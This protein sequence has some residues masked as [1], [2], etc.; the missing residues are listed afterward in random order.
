MAPVTVGGMDAFTHWCEVC[1]KEE[2]LTSDEAFSAG[3][4][5]PPGM[6]TW[7]VV[8][9]RTCGSCPMDATVWWAVAMDGYDAE[10]L[11]SAQRRVVARIRDETPGGETAAPSTDCGPEHRESLDL[12]DGGSWVVSTRSGSH[13]LFHLDGDERSV[14]RLTVDDGHVHAD[15]SHPL[16][17][18]GEVL[19]LRGLVD[20][21]I[22]VGR[23]AY[24]VLGDVS[25]DPDC[26][27][28]TRATTPVVQIRR[29]D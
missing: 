25:D 18:D 27:S 14:V 4:D 20:P 22:Q 6:G 16:R 7:G 5:F 2:M 15:G 13:Y 11:S 23:P 21:P 10:Q 8:S 28:T 1:G 26:T 3:W 19:P 24:L 9:P 12:D 17:R 29:L